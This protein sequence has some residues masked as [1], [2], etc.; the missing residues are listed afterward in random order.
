[1]GARRPLMAG[2]WKMNP[3]EPWAAVA[4]AEQVVAEAAGHPGPEVGVFPPFVWLS[5]VADAVSGTQILVGAQN[6]HWEASG[7]H[8][9]EVS[10]AMLAQVCG[11]VILGHSERRQAGETSAQV[12][13]KVAA[14]RVHGLRCIV[15]V[16]ETIDQRRAGEAEAVVARQL[17][18]SLG[19]AELDSGPEVVIAYEPVWAIGT[20]N[21]CSVDDAERMLRVI[22]AG[23]GPAGAT[24]RLL[25]GGS[26]NPDNAAGY[27]ALADCDG[28]LVGG[29]SL[30]ASQFGRMIEIAARGWR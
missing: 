30:K 8:T 11:A 13:Q 23:L 19:G 28:C 5:L 9:G 29:A 20:G 24:T 16:G 27:L 15:C 26:A 2:N 21:S 25:Y 7:A 1:M 22:R 6:C 3:I 12:A 10:P 14:A 17:A 4:L 18:E